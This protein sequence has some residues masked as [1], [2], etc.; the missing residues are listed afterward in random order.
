MLPE[1]SFLLAESWERTTPNSGKKF[2]VP[3]D[4]YWR[5]YGGTKNSLFLPRYFQSTDQG[6]GRPNYVEPSTVSTCNYGATK[7]KAL[8]LQ[9]ITLLA[10][11]P[12]WTVAKRWHRYRSFLR[13]K[14]PRWC[15]DINSLRTSGDSGEGDARRRK[16]ILQVTRLL[17]Y[18]R[19]LWGIRC[20]KERGQQQQH[21]N[22]D[23]LGRRMPS[24]LVPTGAHWLVK[25]CC[26]PKQV[27]RA[28]NIH[29]LDEAYASMNHVTHGLASF[30][31]KPDGGRFI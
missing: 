23:E 27:A 29:E 4:R 24:C 17:L 15:L 8:L 21:R 28:Q 30:Q 20:W 10:L 19:G 18:W 1:I 9:Q 6:P 25:T 14:M 13:R 26:P 12:L 16:E 22:E 31:L 3:E 7:K 11:L 2:R 5:S